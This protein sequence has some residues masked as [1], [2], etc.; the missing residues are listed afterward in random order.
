MNNSVA[1]L[2]FFFLSSTAAMAG[3][4]ASVPEGAIPIENR[5][6]IVRKLSGR[7]DSMEALDDLGHSG[8]SMRHL[9]AEPEAQAFVRAEASTGN[10]EAPK[11]KKRSVIANPNAK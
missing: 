2:T 11:I 1:F 5:A 10:S 7:S 6:E 3:Q 8:R 4:P 9:S